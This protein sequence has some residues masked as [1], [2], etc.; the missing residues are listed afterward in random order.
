VLSAGAVIAIGSVVLTVLYGQTRVLVAMSRDGLVP[1]LFSRIGKRR[2]PTANTLVVG[3]VVAVLAALVPLGQLA[4]ATSIGT[5]VAFGLVNVGVVVL[6]R[7]R[8]DLPRT[9]RTPL[10]PLVPALGLGLCLLLAFGLAG[11]TWVAFGIWSVAGLV[12]YFG[13][14]RRRSALARRG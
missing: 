3:C 5:L 4:E 1:G 2:V 9:F 13:Y 10:M 7:K 8:P 6:R 11:V 12:V 14:G